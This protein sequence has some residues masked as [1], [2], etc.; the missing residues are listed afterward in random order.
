M[1]KE[2]LLT[3]HKESDLSEVDPKALEH[4]LHFISMDPR[5]LARVLRQ[6]IIHSLSLEPNPDVVD[7]RSISD[8][9]QINYMADL[10]DDLK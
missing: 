4:L 2:V 3:I 9:A 10:L 6:T 1:E 7:N 5:Q 8:V